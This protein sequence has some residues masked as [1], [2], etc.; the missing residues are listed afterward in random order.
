MAA[1]RLLSTIIYRK[2]KNVFVV[3]VVGLAKTNWI[4]IE[5]MKNELHSICI[6]YAL[7]TVHSAYICLYYE[8]A[9][10]AWRCGAAWLCQM[11]ATQRGCALWCLFSMYVGMSASGLAARSQRSDKNT[12]YAIRRPPSSLLVYTLLVATLHV[13]FCFSFRFVYSQQIDPSIKIYSGIHTDM[14]FLVCIV[15]LVRLS[16]EAIKNGNLAQIHTYIRTL[17]HALRLSVTLYNIHIPVKL[18]V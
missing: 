1:K 4:R 13:R 9:R 5:V 3:V 8:W 15:V 17:V 16:I 2:S 18:L 14:D 7:C 6:L 11:A 12:A 10:R